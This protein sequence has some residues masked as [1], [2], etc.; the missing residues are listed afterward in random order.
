M[1]AAAQFAI[2]GDP[3]EEGEPGRAQ[4]AVDGGFGGF[5]Q[6]VRVHDAQ[7]RRKGGRGHVVIDHQQV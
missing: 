2:Q 1:A 7:R 6:P 3:H 5:I 4:R